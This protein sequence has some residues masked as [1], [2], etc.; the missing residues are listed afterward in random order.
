MEFES[1]RNQIVQQLARLAIL[2][3]E[4]RGYTGVVAVSWLIGIYTES[5]T[6]RMSEEREPTGEADPLSHDDGRAAKL[7]RGL[8][9]RLE[10]RAKAW[11]TPDCFFQ[12]KDKP[13]R[14]P[15]LG[16]ATT[17][18]FSFFGLVGAQARG[19]RRRPRR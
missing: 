12:R 7:L 17:L 11:T 6:I 15:V 4:H 8:V 1:Q 5:C 14:D 13:S 9:Q 19:P 3:Y 10:H 18:G 2:V 16:A